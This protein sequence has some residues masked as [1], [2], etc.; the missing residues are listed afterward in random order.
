MLPRLIT[1]FGMGFL[2]AK[3]YDKVNNFLGNSVDNLFDYL[4][5][6]N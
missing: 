2:Y 6:D 4:F 3:N 1:W 5:Q